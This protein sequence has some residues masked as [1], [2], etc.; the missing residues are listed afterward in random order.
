[1]KLRYGPVGR[2]SSEV[3]GSAA[4][5]RAVAIT[6]PHELLVEL[7]FGR[8]R[9]VGMTTT[10]MFHVSGIVGHPGYLPESAE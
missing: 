2:L 7:A 3:S 6:S 1:M 5:G 9:A 8:D 4:A 10:Q